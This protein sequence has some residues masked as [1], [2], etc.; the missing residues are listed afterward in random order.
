M[1]NSSDSRTTTWNRE[2]WQNDKWW[3][4]REQIV[5]IMLSRNKTTSRPLAPQEYIPATH[6]RA[7]PAMVPN[8]QQTHTPWAKMKEEQS[9]KDIPST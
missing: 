8:A 7:T 9:T 4:I 1:R 3:G 5:Y 6:T 2:T